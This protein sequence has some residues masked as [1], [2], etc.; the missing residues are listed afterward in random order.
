MLQ[1]SGFRHRL[2][3]QTTRIFVLKHPTSVCN[4]PAKWLLRYI[5]HIHLR[6]LADGPLALD[7][8]G[9]AKVQEGFSINGGCYLVNI[10]GRNSPIEEL[11]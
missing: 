3:R 10:E 6:P 11:R 9:T 4:S 1:R 8:S 7:A 2:G 5:V